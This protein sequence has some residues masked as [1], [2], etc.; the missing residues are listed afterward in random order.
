MAI[1]NLGSV[2]DLINTLDNLES[3]SSGS[4]IDNT[5]NG[6]SL[7]LE[8]VY[9]QLGSDFFG[10]VKNNSPLENE[11]SAADGAQWY[12]DNL[13]D[14]RSLKNYYG[15]SFPQIIETNLQ[16]VSAGGRGVAWWPARYSYLVL[17]S[18]IKFPFHIDSSCSTSFPLSEVHWKY[19]LGPDA[20]KE[21]TFQVFLATESIVENYLKDHGFTVSCTPPTTDESSNL[22]QGRQSALFFIQNLNG[23]IYLNNATLSQEISSLSHCYSSFQSIGS[24]IETLENFGGSAQNLLNELDKNTVQVTLI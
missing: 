11:I 8:E 7:A 13:Q 20:G 3:T 24:S 23:N 19:T 1:Q 10:W 15:V 14:I 9:T 18:D 22:L 16:Y 6:V 2:P 12:M 4:S 5:I 21:E 17:G